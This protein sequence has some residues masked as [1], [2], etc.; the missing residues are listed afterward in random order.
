[1]AHHEYW[2]ALGN[3][4]LSPEAD[5]GETSTGKRR[6][7]ILYI[8][9]HRRFK[10]HFRAYPW[11][12]EL[13]ARGHEVDVMCHANTERW[14]TR[15]EQTEGFRIIENPDLLAG[16]LR[17]GWDPVCACRRRNF[18]FRENKDYDLIHC[19]DTRLAVV[20][21]AMAYARAKGIPIF[22]DWIDWWGRGGLI[23]ER[24]PWWYRITLGSVET[25]FEEHFRN[26]L[27]GLTAISHA[28]IGRALDLGVPRDRCLHIPGGA[29]IRAFGE[30]PSQTESKALSGIPSEA[31]VLCFSGLD[32]LIDL[33][34]AVRAYEQVRQQIPETVL[35]LIGP[36]ESGAAAVVSD[37][38][39]LKGIV[40][41]GPLPYAELPQR[42]AAADVFLMPF[43]HKVSNIGR[44]PN[45]IGD[46]MCVG[47]P[48]VSNPVGEVKWLF[49]QYD[50]GVLTE[51]TA[52]A[53][54]KA[55]LELL[56]DRAR[57]EALGARA[58]VVAEEVFAWDKLILRLEQWYYQMI[59]KIGKL[60]SIQRDVLAHHRGAESA[61]H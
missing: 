26:K 16:S 15:I 61:L 53:M 48:T 21:P 40:A 5:T 59:D 14:R 10:I 22:S 25:W 56:R 42:L 45:K 34:L 24:R 2:V 35:L 30:I 9:N 31:P 8:S 51:P 38:E 47:R 19:L 52:E 44:W 12:R 36:T 54:A 37:P 32:V 20:L 28:L 50:I 23:A 46:Y 41:T 60:D 43:D 1:M 58:R 13:A 55:A 6:L 4:G 7:R 27:D 33:K 49:D 17:Q 39:A 18:L 11:A 3:T 29:N 57:A